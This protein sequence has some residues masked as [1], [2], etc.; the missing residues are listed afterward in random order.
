MTARLQ[1]LR[2][3]LAR[4]VPAAGALVV[5]GDA[6]RQYLSG[7]RG[8]SGLL[9]ITP[10]DAALVTDARFWEQAEQECPDWRLVRQQGPLAPVLAGL[11]AE[12]GVKAVAFQ[13]E[14][15]S[16]ATYRSWRR[17]MVGVRLV[18]AAAL[19]DGLRLRKDARELEA[20]RRAASLTDDVFAQW[21]P[22]C[23]AGAV[24]AELALDLEVRLR[25]A[26]AQGV[27]FAPIVA[28]GPRGAM[29]HA[30]AG[31]GRLAAGDLVV[32]DVGARVDG[33][34]S[35]MTRT[36]VVPGAAPLPDA[37]AARALV[38]EAMR[39]GVAALRPGVGAVEV[40]AVVRAVITTGGHGEHFG[41]GTG[42]GVGLEVHEPPRISPHGDPEARIPQGA[43]VTVEPGVYVAGRFG[44]RLEQL[45]HV[46]A[47]GPEVLSRSPVEV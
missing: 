43:V 45:V 19:V 27:S 35:D 8:D 1:A 28:A 32:V 37:V 14:L 41:H 42:H 20:I 11:A 17:A 44:V 3:A 6:D 29:A 33:Y 39:A 24:E 4:H 9:W 2:Q 31:P 34:C 36:V 22:Q 46:G 26:G 25:R 40:D 15:V 38:A 47:D 30:L 23:R 13:P 10:D 5:S 16:H 12:V 21:L 7:F 18:A